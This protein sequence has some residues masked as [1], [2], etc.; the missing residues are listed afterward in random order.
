M[1]YM[2]AKNCFQQFGAARTVLFIAGALIATNL[3]P[4]AKADTIYTYT[5][6]DYSASN[7]GG[8]YCTGTVCPL[9]YV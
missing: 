7:C 1:K 2:T 9:N 6:N 3:A 8:T 4:S 5:G